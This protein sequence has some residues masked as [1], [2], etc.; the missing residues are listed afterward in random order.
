MKDKN[1]GDADFKMIADGALLELT[2][3]AYRESMRTDPDFMKLIQQRADK[4]KRLEDVLKRLSDDDRKA[5]EDYIAIILD[6][7]A[8]MMKSI[9]LRGAKD[10]ILLLDEYPEC[11]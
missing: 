5:V 10:Y 7:S 3:R 9:Y 8:R 4:D 1:G 11:R 2:N 6:C